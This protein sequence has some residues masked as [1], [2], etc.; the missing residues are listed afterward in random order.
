MGG[1]RRDTVREVDIVT[2]C[3]LMI[4]RELWEQLG[5]FDKDFFMYGEEADLCLRAAA[6]GAGPII[7]PDAT[8]V[9]LGGASEKV[10][11]DKVVRL[12][13]AKRLLE[14]RHWAKRWWAY[15][16]VMRQLWV[17]RRRF[18]WGVLRLTGSSTAKEKVS[19]Y[20]NVWSRRAEWLEEISD[21]RN[22]SASAKATSSEQ[23]S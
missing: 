22:G 2:G 13:R 3:F 17:F 15:G 21:S 14:R 9:H 6:I 20:I 23:T 7:C 18:V 12:L 1:W 11:A 8:L 19:V 5:G 10:R 4:R 16:D